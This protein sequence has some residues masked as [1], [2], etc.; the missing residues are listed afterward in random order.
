M[1]H[2]KHCYVNN[3]NKSA[4]Q[5]SRR[6][7]L[8]FKQASLKAFTSDFD[9]CDKDLGIDSVFSATCIESNESFHQPN[10]SATVSTSACDSAL[11]GFN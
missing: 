3:I 6:V 11:N 9:V 2:N 8:M 10:L 7:D 1:S 5:G 4:A